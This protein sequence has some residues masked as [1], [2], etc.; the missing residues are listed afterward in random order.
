MV[1]CLSV[2]RSDGVL[3]SRRVSFSE[4]KSV[5]QKQKQIRLVS[6]LVNRTVCPSPV[7]CSARSVGKSVDQSAS[8]LVSHNYL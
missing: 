1:V 3:V 4:P 5:A 2:G 6:P 8:Q 7:D